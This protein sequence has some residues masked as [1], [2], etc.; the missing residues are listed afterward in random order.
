MPAPDPGPAPTTMKAIVQYGYGSPDVLEL[1]E[2]ARPAVGDGEVLV[3]VHAAEL[4]RFFT[5]VSLVSGPLI[6]MGFNERATAD[7]RN[8]IVAFFDR[9]LKP[10]SPPGGS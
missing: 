5:L 10:P 4:P 2:I 7:A 1:E 3:H 9:H 6:G 8:R